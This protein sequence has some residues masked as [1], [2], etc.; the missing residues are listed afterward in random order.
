MK[1]TNHRE[2]LRLCSLGI[3]N[4]R[5][6]ESMGITR[7][8]VITTLQRAAAQ[9]VDWSAAEELSDRELVARLFP[10]GD[11]KPCCKMPDYDWVHREMAKPGMTQQLLWFEYCD[12]CRA[13][14]EIPYQLTQFKTHYRAYVAK[15]KATM[16]IQ[17]K[18]GE[19]MEVDWAGQTASLVDADTGEIS[20]AYVFVAALPYSGYAYAEAFVHQGQEPWIMAHVHAYEFFGGVA[21]ILVPDNLKTGVTKNTR[22]ELVLNRSY[23][24]LAEHYG[25]AIIPTRVRSPKDKPTVE[26]AVG[27]ISSAILAGIRNQTFFT[28]RE[29]NAVI[30]EK[31][32]SLNHKPF[33]K[34]DGSRASWF[35]EERAS[36]LPLPKNAYELATWKVAT[37]TFNYH[38]AVEEQYYS[39]PFAYIKRKVDVRVTTNVVEVFCEHVRLCSHVRLHGRR[40]QYSTQ[41]AHMP[42]KHQQYIQWNGERFRSWATK[43]GPQTAT[44]VEAI[45]TG[46]K[47]EQQGYRACM[48]LLKLSD[49][50][51]AKRLEAACERAL[52]YTP[53]PSYKSIQT[54]LK[55]GQDIVRE[56]PAAPPVPSEFGFTRG[57]DYY[58]GG[59]N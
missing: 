46:Y 48:A 34:K 37:V 18:P 29:L 8:T 33:Q 31:L 55:S 15:T 56:A 35:A 20:E 9:G 25:T 54:I 16:H 40:G 28:L 59:S 49:Q 57:A 24:E 22:A 4:S 19:L 52:F 41:E 47:V 45:L 26:G 51:S 50:Y 3:N 42:P 5:I 36:L 1:M 13:A 32:H 43:I 7:Q 2:I 10:Q 44:V 27:N 23:Q 17:R 53:R 11:G 38:I 21:R 14:G 39:V 12:Q 58:K 30:R 6:A